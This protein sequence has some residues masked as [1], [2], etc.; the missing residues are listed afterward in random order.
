MLFMACENETP[1]VDAPEVK[2]PVLTLT[3]DDSFSFTAEGGMFT[4]VY[5]VENATEDTVVE[6]VCS[7]EGWI[8]LQQAPEA[9]ENEYSYKVLANESEA[10]RSATVTVSLDAQQYVV[11]VE[12]AGAVVIPDMPEDAVVLP[13]LSAIYYG[14]QYGATENDYNYSLALATHENVLDIVTG[15]SNIKEEQ[16][17]L[18]LDLYSATPSERYN[19]EFNIPDGTYTLDVNDTAEAGTIGAYYSMLYDTTDE[20][21]AVYPEVF[22]VE[23]TVVVEDGIIVATLKGEDGVTYKFATPTTY[24]DN[25]E[26]FVGDWFYHGESFTW[27]TE[28]KQIELGNA[29]IKGSCMGDYYVVGKNSWIVNISGD[30]AGVYSEFKFEL[31]VPMEDSRP[32]GEFPVSSNLDLEQM[33]LPGFISSYGVIEWSW[34]TWD[35]GRAPI[36]DGKV[37]FVENADGTMTVIF[38]LVDDAGY[39]ITGECTAEFEDYTD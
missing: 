13:Y 17:Y 29:R 20:T 15:E 1:G 16:I 32:V 10:P 39:K 38:D 33:A 27:L 2:E 30:D 35:G 18:F 12:Q 8:E 7:A 11:T 36:A 28:D 26:F 9:P 3:S 37:T 6:V 5:S 24:V 14:N 4:V 19:I 23:G 22:F 31:L 25:R 34:L 21:A